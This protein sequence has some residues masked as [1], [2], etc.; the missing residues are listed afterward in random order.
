MA[1]TNSVYET[2]DVNNY[3]ASYSGYCVSSQSKMW[4]EVGFTTSANYGVYRVRVKYPDSTSLLYGYSRNLLAF[5]GNEL[6]T[7]FLHFFLFGLQGQGQM[8]FDD[9]GRDAPG[10]QA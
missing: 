3:P 5:T 8:L 2:H 6:L 7:L 10:I 1:I 4:H 9:S